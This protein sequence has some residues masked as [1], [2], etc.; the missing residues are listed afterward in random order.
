MTQEMK[1]NFTRRIS[2]ANPS[3]LVV[4]VYEIALESMR[5]AL[6][7]APGSAAFSDALTRAI[8]CVGNLQ[9]ALNLEYG[10]ARNL[11]SLYAYASRELSRAKSS[12]SAEGVRRAQTV[13]AG[14]HRAFAQV[15]AEDSSAPLM[16]N[17][18]NVYAGLTYGRGELKEN[19]DPGENRGYLA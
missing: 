17:T 15:A 4:I 19:A 6:E 7:E 14:L 3:G 12:G 9:R 11:L 13:M 10:L 8:N 1:Q 16:S 2:Q 5:E 18:Q